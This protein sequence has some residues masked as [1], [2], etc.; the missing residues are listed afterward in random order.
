MTGALSGLRRG[1]IFGLQWPDVDV[2]NGR[3]GGVLH[4]R[5]SI[6]H[7]VLGTPKTPD[8]ERTVDVPQRLLDELAI[9]RLAYPSLGDGFIFRTA[10]GRPLEPDNWHKRRLVPMLT[11]AGVYK[12]G[13]GLN[14]L[15][16]GYVSLLAALGEDIHYI[17]RQVGHS[18]TKLTQDIYRHTFA[19]ARVSSMRR[20][21]EA[22]S[23]PTGSHLTNPS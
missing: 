16:H 3:D 14:A 4:V 2:G 7:G 21:N 12:K 17:S 15:R 19:K 10:A 8:S 6:Y 22:V 9:Y 20:L 18:S 23:P 1:E 11:T 13:M 5:R